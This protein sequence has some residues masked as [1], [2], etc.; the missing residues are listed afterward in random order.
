VSANRRVGAWACATKWLNRI[1]Q[2]FSPGYATLEDV[3]KRAPERERWLWFQLIQ[4][5]E[6]LHAVTEPTRSRATLQSPF[7]SDAF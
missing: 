2:G 1:A 4:K 5:F 7:E 3:P 6:V